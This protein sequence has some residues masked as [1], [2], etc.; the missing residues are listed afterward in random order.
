ME[1]NA[2]DF[3][4][5]L[6]VAPTPPEKKYIKMNGEERIKY[7]E[8]L[9][10]HYLNAAPLFVPEE[11]EF[12]IITARKNREDVQQASRLWLEKNLPGKKYQIFFLASPKTYQ[13]VIKFKAEVLNTH[14]VSNFYEDNRTVL[15]GLKKLV[16]CNLWFYVKGGFELV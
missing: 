2:W 7:R 15:K 14:N 12:I 10:N 13:N 16:K 6:C 1:Y 9:I 5:V 11:E 4:G 8:N 3:D